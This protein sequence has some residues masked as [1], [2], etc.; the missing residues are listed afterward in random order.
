MSNSGYDWYLKNKKEYA[1]KNSDVIKEVNGHKDTPQYILWAKTVAEELEGGDAKCVKNDM[2]YFFTEQLVNKLMH[3]AY[4]KG[5][6]A[7]EE[8]SYKK[9]WDDCLNDVGKK[10]G[11]DIDD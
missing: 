9:G 7:I 6:K 5:T 1:E 4:L 2:G 8:N 11:F 3:F 10:L